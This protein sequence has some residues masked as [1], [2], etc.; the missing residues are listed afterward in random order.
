M[1]TFPNASSSQPTAPPGS[2]LASSPTPVPAQIQRDLA[3]LVRGSRYTQLARAH[4][5]LRQNRVNLCAGIQYYA[6][7]LRAKLDR[8]I[9]RCEQQDN[10]P[11]IQRHFDA[12][13]TAIL[14]DTQARINRLESVDRETLFDSVY[15]SDDEY[16]LS[17]SGDR[18]ASCAQASCAVDAHAAEEEGCVFP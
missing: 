2:L 14:A 8:L 18:Q 13:A 15:E 16:V 6:P 3:F 7:Y 4:T 1:S 12:L 10:N 17:V 9:S 11:D 5:G